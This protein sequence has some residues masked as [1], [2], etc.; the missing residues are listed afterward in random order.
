[1][2][3]LLQKAKRWIIFKKCWGKKKKKK[4]KSLCRKFED[5]KNYFEKDDLKK[6]D[7]KTL[8]ITLIEKKETSAIEIMQQKNDI[9]RQKIRMTTLMTLRK[10][11]LWI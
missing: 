5:T 6:E 7:L 2:L 9:E 3:N 10:I 4:T 11:K 1:M 8:K